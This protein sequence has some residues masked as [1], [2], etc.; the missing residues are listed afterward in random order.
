MH[1]TFG[2]LIL[3]LAFTLSVI[4]TFAVASR[5]FSYVR[6]ME[7]GGKFS[8][9]SFWDCVILGKEDYHVFGISNAEYI[10][11]VADEPGDLDENLKSNVHAESIR[12]DETAQWVNDVQCHSDDSPEAPASESTLIERRFSRGS[13]NSDDTVHEQVRFANNS[14][15]SRRLGILV[16]ATAERTLVF[17]GFAQLMHGVVI[18]TGGCRETYLNGCLAHIISK[19]CPICPISFH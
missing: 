15:L 8:V 11:L 9:R 16:F 4:D 14:S 17:A 3:A 12:E 10:N 5:L 2:Y 1:C 18:Y 13:Q 6:S 19:F 7:K